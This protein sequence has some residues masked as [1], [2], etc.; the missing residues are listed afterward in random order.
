MLK[1]INFSKSRL[2][3]I[4]KHIS[5][6]SVR[7]QNE[8]LVKYHVRDDALRVVEKKPQRPPLVKNFF[9]GS[10]D[11][12]LLAYPEVIYENEQLET[13]KQRK[14]TY[15]DFLETNIF[16]NPDDVNNINKLKEFGCFKSPSPLVTEAMYS[17]SESDAKYLSYGTFLNNH[18]LVLK[19]INEFGESSQKLKYLPM[20][21]SGDSIATPCLFEAKLRKQSKKLF[22]V[23]AKFNDTTE[24]WILNGEKNYVLISPAHKNSTTFLVI[25]SAEKVDHIGNP[26][27]S[28]VA[29]I[30]DAAL[31]G[32]S[33]SEVDQTIGF[34][35]KT[36]NQVT[37]S[38]KDVTLD[39]CKTFNVLSA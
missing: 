2:N 4:C 15:D 6:S 12:E 39:K 30:V 29:L 13:A 9:V 28:L 10:I 27:D 22:D 11:T 19:L 32:V 35:E 26:E 36:F 25:G 1:L 3:Y 18:Q 33:I 31:P 38:F 20:L 34:G 14:K 24:K 37:V 23:E 16:S 21:E 17:V 7:L 5:T 8:E